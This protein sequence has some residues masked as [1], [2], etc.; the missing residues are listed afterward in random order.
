MR[1]WVDVLTPKQALFTKAMLE[2]AP[3]DF[4]LLITSRNYAELNKFLAQI[5]MKH[6]SF[7]R[8]GGPTV[9]GKL[10]A[11]IERMDELV[12][13]VLRE[14]PDCSFSFISPEAARVSFGL[15]IAHFISSD[16]PHAQAPCKLAVPLAKKVFTPFVIKKQR[17]TQYGIGSYQVFT[18]HALD[19]WAWLLSKRKETTSYPRQDLVLIRLEES[20][21]SYAKSGKGISDVLDTLIR[22]IKSLV[23]FE[24]VIIPR[25][26]EQREWA[27]KKFGKTC[28]VPSTTIE[29]IDLVSKASL[30]IGGGGTMTQ[31]AA[32]LGIPNIS[33]FPSTPLDVFENYCFP[34]QLSVRASTPEELIKQ[35]SKLL[36]NIEVARSEFE[37]RAHKAVR[38]FEDPV[39]IVFKGIFEDLEKVKKV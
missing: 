30:L 23:D 31:E 2:R 27:K 14:N 1:I 38:S 37:E 15:G 4:D 36:S 10:K 5:G 13:F 26:D 29:G 18:Y 7:G 35:T 11:S 20:F 8:H 25:Y 3:S 16:S 24:I 39:E 6:R 9:L 21:A 17:W 34:K 28:T 19:P 12:P 22:K 32:L 33:Y